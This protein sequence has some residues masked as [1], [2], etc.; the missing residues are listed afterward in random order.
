MEGTS[1][2][3]SSTLGNLGFTSFSIAILSPGKHI[4]TAVYN[5]DNKFATST[6]SAWSH[7][8]NKAKTTTAL[9][10]SI[11]PSVI[12]QS[13]KFT[14]TVNGAGGTPSGNVTFKDG[15][16]VLSSNVALVGGS[17]SI[18]INTLTVGSHNITASYNGDGNYNSSTSNTVKQTVN[19]ISTSIVL[20]SG[21]NPSVSGQSVKFTATL[22][23]TAATGSITF[24][25]GNSTLGTGILSG[26]I[27][28]YNT[29]LAV[30]T[31]NITA[32]Y[33]GNSTYAASTS[34]TITQAVVAKP[35]IKTT[36]L[37]GGTNNKSY[38]QMLS[39]SGGAAPFTWAITGS[40]PPGLSL[41]A[42]T[43]AISGK[44]TATGTF[45][46]TVKVTDSLGNTVTQGLS[47][48]INN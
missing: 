41:N 14:A 19:K 29:T 10:S 6:S 15:G 4:I 35:V 46:F 31:H 44:P 28:T 2:L 11:N 17:A 1:L 32:V 7:T 37:P 13:V 48:K 5:G 26:G 40:L 30:G 18:D 3:G 16:T 43:G 22:S 27:A 25:D 47:I 9:T 36:S 24:K 42:S 8:V 21:T 34:N 39:V 38:S 45:S 20:S 12:T 33:A 23:P